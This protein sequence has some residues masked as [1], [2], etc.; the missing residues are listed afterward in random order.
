VRLL[1][2]LFVQEMQEEAISST[3]GQKLAEYS[4]SLTACQI[5]WVLFKVGYF[6][7]LGEN[8]YGIEF[9]VFF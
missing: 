9:R 1:K 8:Y 2:E 6:L 7:S 4:K 3:P 5:L